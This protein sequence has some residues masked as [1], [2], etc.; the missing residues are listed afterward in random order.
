MIAGPSGVG[1]GTVV[2]RVR[3]LMPGQLV[4]SVSAT[5]RPP[6]PGEAEGTDYL[7]VDDAAFDRMVEQGELLEWAEVFHG[8]RYGTPAGSVALHREA[9]RD[10]LLEIDVE[11]ARWV[12]ERAPDAVMILLEPP[13]RSELER[14]LRSRGTESDASIAERLAKADWELGQAG[15]F[16]HVVVND[17]LERASAEVAAIIEASR[18]RSDA[19]GDAAALDPTEDPSA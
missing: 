8:H 17:D 7:F 19:S 4:L 15:M 11:G 16:D 13:S 1:K 2:R 5:T 12:H 3:S 6:R 9:G 10:V 14:R 18:A